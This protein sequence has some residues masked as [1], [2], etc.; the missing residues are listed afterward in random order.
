MRVATKNDMLDLGQKQAALFTANNL[1]Y[2]EILVTCECPRHI[3]VSAYRCLVRLGKLAPIE[4]L[5]QE[6]KEVAWQ[7]AKDIAKGR[8]GQKALVEVVQALLTIEYFLNL[9]N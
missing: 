3:L 8:M 7:T 9:E 4:D 2:C 1:A 5:L 6:Q